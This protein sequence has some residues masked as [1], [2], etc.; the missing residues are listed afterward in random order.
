MRN[1]IKIKI[2][3][4]IIALLSAINV[5]AA[6][7]NY[8]ALVQVK[9]KVRDKFFPV[10]GDSQETVANL[11]N[12][13][14]DK[15]NLDYQS[16]LQPEHCRLTLVERELNPK[17]TLKDAGVGRQVF[18][19]L[20]EI[21]QTS[22][23]NPKGI[24]SSEPR[25]FVYVTWGQNKYTIYH[26]Q[27]E[28]IAE[29]AA[30]V[31]S[32]YNEN[33][34]QKLSP[35]NYMLS[36]AEGRTLEPTSRLGNLLKGASLQLVYRPSSLAKPAKPAVQN[37]A[38]TALQAGTNMTPHQV[39]DHKHQAEIS[40]DKYPHSSFVKFGFKSYYMRFSKEETVAQFINR[41][42][43]RYLYKNN[44]N[45][46]QENLVFLA[47][48]RAF[49]GND[50][51][52]QAYMPNLT[53]IHLVKTLNSYKKQDKKESIK[54]EN[55]PPPSGSVSSTSLAMASEPTN[56]V[57]SYNEPKINRERYEDALSR[58]S[59]ALNYIREYF[60]GE[61]G[62]DYYK[63]NG[64]AKNALGKLNLIKASLEGVSHNG[65]TEKHRMHGLACLS[66]YFFYP[67]DI[68]QNP[69]ELKALINLKTP[70]MQ[71]A[72][73]LMEHG[74]HIEPGE[75]ITDDE[76]ELCE[77]YAG[78]AVLH[79]TLFVSLA[80]AEVRAREKANVLGGDWQ[81]YFPEYFAYDEELASVVRENI[82][83]E[84]FYD[85]TMSH[86]REYIVIEQ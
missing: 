74:G 23:E 58:Q 53:V 16:N 40:S 72:R 37:Q 17:L 15:F 84:D 38:G 8:K 73:E 83:V 47:R 44:K 9:V 54:K 1:I 30:R 75:M 10:M 78:R 39:P 81:T 66:E 56:D 69:L 64:D 28:T 62:Y 85:H 67:E 6:D 7:A 43:E 12:R 14:V 79:H 32:L 31:I 24:A 21:P 3:S 57:K 27:S 60:Y 86:Y 80:Q 49:Y 68:L 2:F 55:P 41:F 42:C 26:D 34:K 52:A 71:K 50:T 77:K 59:Q 4:L 65:L 25:P 76:L 35:I 51:L 11:R 82:T 13:I 70:E 22:L 63:Q 61:E 45:I 29:I 36:L 18:M 19:E 20:R 5:A 48:G 46:D 33:Y